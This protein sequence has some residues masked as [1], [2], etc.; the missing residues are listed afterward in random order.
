ML[1]TRVTSDS[2]G[3][4]EIQ[5]SI[6]VVSRSFELPLFLKKGPEELMTQL[7]LS[8]IQQSERNHS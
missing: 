1:V 8:K 4:H 6:D 3:H 7:G 2:D 5:T